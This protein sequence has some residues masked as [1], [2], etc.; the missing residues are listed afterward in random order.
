MIR[1]TTPVMTYDLIEIPNAFFIFNVD[2][3][4]NQFTT[5]VEKTMNDTW[6]TK[7][8]YKTVYRVVAELIDSNGNI[9]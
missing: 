7:K 3:S 4:K 2:S 1:L 8:Q 9:L 5:I 6:S